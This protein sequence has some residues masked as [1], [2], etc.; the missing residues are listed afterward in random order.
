MKLTAT[1]HD[2]LLSSLSFQKV[3][4]FTKGRIEEDGVQIA[5]IQSTLSDSKIVAMFA[6]KLTIKQGESKILRIFI[7]NKSTADLGVTLQNSQSI[8]S[9]AEQVQG[10]FPYAFIE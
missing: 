9:S 2:I 3:G 8:S 7:Q 10:S 4:E 6:P 5:I 1:D